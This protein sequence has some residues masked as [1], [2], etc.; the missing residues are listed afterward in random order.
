[1]PKDLMAGGDEG[2]LQ[3][4]RGSAA[5]QAKHLLDIFATLCSK[6]AFQDDSRTLIT[7]LFR[8]D[9]ADISTRMAEVSEKV[10]T[11]AF[12]SYGYDQAM[13]GILRSEKG[14]LAMSKDK[15]AYGDICKLLAS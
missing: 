13:M 7:R 12:T 10:K 8:S 14:R 6:K 1:M 5:E 2:W 11:G 9:S 4:I 15:E 3:P